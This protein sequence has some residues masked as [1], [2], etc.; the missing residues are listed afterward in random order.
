MDTSPMQPRSWLGRIFLSPSEPRLRA[1]WRILGHFMLMI[2][3]FTIGSFALTPLYLLAP[4]YLLLGSQIVSFLVITLS[5]PIAR[6]WL[7]R[8]SFASLGL[9]WDQYA[10]RD[11]ALGLGLP[12]LMFGSI[13][14]IELAFGWLVVDGFAWQ[15]F[16]PSVILRETAVIGFM[17]ILVGWQEE[18]L[19]RGYWL[20]NLSEGLGMPL[21]VILTSVVFAVGHAFNPNSS[22]VSTLGLVLAGLFF[23]Y[24]Y[25]A[26]RQLWLPIGLHIA[27]NF[28]EGPIF[29]FPVSGVT[30]FL[31]LIQH[32]DIGPALITGGAFGPEAGLIQI[33]ALLLG[34]LVIHFYTR[35][36]LS[37]PGAHPIPVEP[38]A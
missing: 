38:A 17:F 5:V 23:A 28:L 36:R 2:V 37:M 33:P 34:V 9:H 1:G 11:L 22:W 8:R 26:T 35:G 16:S 20:V 10:A 6:R 18:L 19:T 32:T 29:G 21:A 31:P 15:T 30:D 14:F 7:D 25:L 12:V 13:F 27:W 3:F 4:Q 24:A